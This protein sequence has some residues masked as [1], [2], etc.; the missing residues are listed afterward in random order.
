MTVFLE[1]LAAAAICVTIVCMGVIIR[2]FSGASAPPR[3]G[4]SVYTVI[5]ADSGT[6]SLECTVSAAL[7]LCASGAR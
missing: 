3:G 7:R 1:S 6:T 4:G 2:T 5:A